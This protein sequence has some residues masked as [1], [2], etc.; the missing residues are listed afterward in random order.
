MKSIWTFLDGK[1]SAIAAIA[2][3]VLAWAQAKNW[4]DDSTAMMLAGVLTGI[5]GIAVG[6]KMVK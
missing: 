6:H 2:G 4:V 3:T 5:T 1:K